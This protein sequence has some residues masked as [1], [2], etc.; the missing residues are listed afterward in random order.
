MVG[1]FDQQRCGSHAART[2]QLHRGRGRQHATPHLHHGQWHLQ[3]CLASATK[4][5]NDCPQTTHGLH[6]PATANCVPLA[7]PARGHEA[8]HRLS[9]GCALPAALHSCSVEVRVPAHPARSWSGTW[10]GSALG[11]LWLFVPTCALFFCLERLSRHYLPPVAAS[12]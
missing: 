3:I 4:L 6:V 2:D 1:L 5:H 7:Q 8:P 10:L 12:G 9:C 11:A